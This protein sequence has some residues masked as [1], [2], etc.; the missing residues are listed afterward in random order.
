MGCVSSSDAA[1]APQQKQ[2][3]EDIQSNNAVEQILEQ[4]R[5]RDDKVLKLLL[6]GA[7]ESGKSTLFKQAVTIYGKGVTQDELRALIIPIH[8]NIIFCMIALCNN[9][10]RYAQ[11]K[12]ENQEAYLFFKSSSPTDDTLLTPEQFQYVQQLWADP[13]IKTCWDHRSEYQIFDCGAYFFDKV[14]Q[15]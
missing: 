15:I 4:K 5:N 12:P 7:G 3:Q 2:H 8:N 14:D 13:A 6:L 9:V 10:D 11:I 1:S